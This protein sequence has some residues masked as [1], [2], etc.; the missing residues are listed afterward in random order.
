MNYSAAP[1][2]CFIVVFVIWVVAKALT[3]WGEREDK[4]TTNKLLEEI[5]DELRKLRT[6]EGG[7]DGKC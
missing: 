6:R 7:F 2:V 5:R 3:R 4:E 1:Y